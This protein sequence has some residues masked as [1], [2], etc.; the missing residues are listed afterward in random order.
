MTDWKYESPWALKLFAF[1]ILDLCLILH[2]LDLFK[3][4][5]TKR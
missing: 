5:G 1:Y 4:H 3:K 2:E